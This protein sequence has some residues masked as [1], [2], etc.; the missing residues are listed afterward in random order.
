MM[1]NMIS[2]HS[3]FIIMM[4]IEIAYSQI[5]SNFIKYVDIIYYVEDINVLENFPN[6]AN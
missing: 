1:A 3:R 2:V 5:A 4:S 6:M